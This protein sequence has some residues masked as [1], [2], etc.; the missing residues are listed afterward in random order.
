MVCV[1]FFNLCFLTKKFE[2][3]V[4]GKRKEKNKIKQEW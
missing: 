2:E 4:K 3:K 1:S